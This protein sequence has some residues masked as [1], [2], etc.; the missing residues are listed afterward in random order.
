MAGR[1]A[2][3]FGAVS[4]LLLSGLVAGCATPVAKS[5]V[6]VPGPRDAALGH[7]PEFSR[8]A[9]E[10]VR[11]EIEARGFEAI[12]PR[13]TA[14]PEMLVLADEPGATFDLT[15]FAGVQQIDMGKL[16]GSGDIRTYGGMDLRDASDQRLAYDSGLLTTP[17]QPSSDLYEVASPADP[18]A[19]TA[20]ADFGSSVLD[21]SREFSKKVGPL[22]GGG[23]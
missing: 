18:R 5:M 4:F 15:L 3:W 20:A 13:S 17:G 21:A 10:R 11:E 1:R 9:A 7:V 2:G 12:V 16:E 14:R 22:L 8:A 23:R 19:L 6:I